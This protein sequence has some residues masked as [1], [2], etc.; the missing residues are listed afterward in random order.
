M[1]WLL[2][3]LP[4]VY[5]AA[6]WIESSYASDYFV[7]LPDS[8]LDHNIKESLHLIE[9]AI[10][11]VLFVFAF[12]TR[13]DGFTRSLNI[14]CALMAAMWGITDEIHQSFNPARSAT[15]IDFIKD[16]IGIG[17]CYYFVNGT[18]FQGKF[19]KLGKVLGRIQGIGSR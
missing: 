18:L 4:L 1:K 12:L 17:V 3:L 15:L 2:R 13:R 9:F 5:M 8:G 16:I 14:A 6:I 7:R 11:Y 19:A 10:L